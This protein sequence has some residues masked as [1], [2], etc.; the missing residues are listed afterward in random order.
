MAASRETSSRVNRRSRTSGGARPISSANMASLVSRSSHRKMTAAC[1]RWLQ[2]IRGSPLR[3]IATWLPKFRVCASEF[4][5]VTLDLFYGGL[6]I[7]L[8]TART[9]Q[10]SWKSCSCR[11]KTRADRRPTDAESRA[12]NVIRHASWGRVASDRWDTLVSFFFNRPS[13]RVNFGR[14]IDTSHAA[15]SL[16]FFAFDRDRRYSRA[17][18]FRLFLS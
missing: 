8:G 3:P 15:S 9:Q 12:R 7:E 2:R 17:W 11:A 1:D 18:A 5:R 10:V 16:C 4:V 13:G 6:R 14:I